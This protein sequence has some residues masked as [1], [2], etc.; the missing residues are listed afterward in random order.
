LTRYLLDT[1]IVSE[2]ARHPRGPCRMQLRRVGQSNVCTSIV[3]AAE[4]RYGLARTKSV[5]IEH[6]IGGTLEHLTI[7]PFDAPADQHYAEVRAYLEARGTPIGPND[8]LIAAHALAL[9]CVLVTDND[10]EFSRVPGLV[11]ENWL[12]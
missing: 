6:A 2:I 11:V 1:N 9:G 10:S 8:V 12:R 4:L 7:E 3:V 5:H